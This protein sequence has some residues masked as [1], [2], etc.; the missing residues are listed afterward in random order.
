M[1]KTFR[2]ILC[3]I[4]FTLSLVAL[5]AL[6]DDAGVLTEGELSNWIN[7]VLAET[8]GQQPQNAPVGEESRTE[9]GYA[10]LYPSATLYYDK[11]V[12]DGASVLHG[13][14]ITDEAAVTPRGI[15]LG[16]PVETLIA[17]YGWQ[18]HELFGDGS[19][20]VFYQLSQLPGGAYWSWAGL[21]EGGISSVRCA[22][23]AAFGTEGMYTDAGILY[24]VQSGVVTSINVYG[25][26]QQ[27]TLAEVE[28]NL[29]A[30]TAVQ[31]SISGD[32][33]MN[34]AVSAAGNFVKSEAPAFYSGDLA[35]EGI[36]FLTLDEKGA[37]ATFGAP[38]Q[39]TWVP[40]GTSGWFYT[41]DFGGLT[42]TFVLDAN[43]QNARLE[44]LN[45]LR[46]GVPGPRGILIGD[47][48]DSVLARFQ[49]DGTGET[50]ETE[51]LLY[52]D[53][54]TPP[55]GALALLDGAATLR[56]VTQADDGGIMRE[57]T[58]RLSF[59]GGQLKDM[60]LY[61]W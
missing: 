57:V 18:N 27:I 59:V 14:A 49:S 8:R 24:Q 60:L 36:D 35:F 6:A 12:L 3:L 21:D 30:V 28:S 16:S 43:K 51:A 9:D 39:E 1:K 5:P 10:F 54:Q 25:L 34:T 46:E 61:S 58:L 26:D 19:L 41:A 22:V 42:L 38:Q 23:H 13:F 52:G 47:T 4:A 40:D 2:G 29:R 7:Q 11:P 45:I 15:R 32:A 48:L 17:A 56:Y 53:G 55:Y 20:A 50:L 44:S 33:G 31:A 37:E